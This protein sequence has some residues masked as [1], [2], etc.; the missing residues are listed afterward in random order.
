MGSPNLF[1]PYGFYLGFLAVYLIYY[2][3]CICIFF[4]WPTKIDLHLLLLHHL[5]KCKSQKLHNLLL[6]SLSH[7]MRPGLQSA[8]FGWQNY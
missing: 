5:R 6:I 8:I 1:K 3:F 4:F 2:V 7:A